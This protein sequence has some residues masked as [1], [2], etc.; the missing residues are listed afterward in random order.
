MGFTPSDIRAGI[1]ME[2]FPKQNAHEE[3]CRGALSE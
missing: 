3:V 1:R 2:F